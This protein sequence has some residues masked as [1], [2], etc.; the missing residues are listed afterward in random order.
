MHQI[1]ILKDVVI[2]F[3]LA[4]IVVFIF[5]KL[6]I[7]SVVGFLLTGILAGPH[8]LGLIN[9]QESTSILAEIGVVLLLFTIGIELSIKKLSKIKNIVFFGGFLQIVLS[10]FVT[11]LVLWLLNV[12]SN[13][14]VF[15]GFL[16]ALSSTAIILKI[17]QEQDQL[18]THH[19]KISI[20]ILI[21]QDLII[22]PMMLLIPMLSG[23][24]N[25]IG[26]EL[27]LMLGKSLLLIGITVVLARWLVP[28]ILHQVALLK[29]QELFLI[30]IFVIG[31]AVANL[32]AL[33][34][35]S[36]AL[37]AFLAGLSISESEYSHHAFGNLVPFRDIFTSFF[38]V[39]I[40]MLLDL[41]FFIDH[42]LIVL[43]V[44][45]ILIFLKSVV[46]GFVSFILGF[47]FKISFRAGLILAQ[48]GEFSFVLVQIGQSH[49]LID[50]F[51]YQLFLA[52]AILSMSF[53]PLLILF[54]DRIS[55]RLNQLPMPKLLKNGMRKLPT[56]SIQTLSRHSIL[57][58]DEKQVGSLM[59][60]FE[61]VDIPFI[62]IDLD[63]DRVR[64]LQ[65]KNINAIYGH[66][67][68][69]SVL[70]HAHIKEASNLLLSLNGMAI[71]ASIIEVAKNLN[72][73]VNIIVRTK[74]L[75]DLDYL[76]KVGADYV[77]LIEFE[78]SIE[79]FERALIHY[80]V[81]QTEINLTIAE[82]RS[83]GYEVFRERSTKKSSNYLGIPNLEISSIE[84]KAQSKI[85][86]K[87]IRELDIR[88]RTGVSIL[89]INRKGDLMTNPNPDEHLLEGDII[90]TMGE[91]SKSIC[92]NDYFN[93]T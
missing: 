81:P 67:Q 49:N 5:Q 58:G 84:I 7:P 46:I 15:I 14:A 92:I 32:S 62:I 6:K 73:N 33:L 60:A 93:E 30:I 29:S 16:V 66:A 43:F 85:I 22:V 71:N 83:R 37:G 52:T 72:P 9:D 21:F 91:F 57:V 34:G 35:L 1:E 28:Y 44:V 47:P 78:T 3:G 17:L 77:I 13:V 45:L 48:I 59:R 75:E 51:Y 69:E 50:G 90:Y 31:F 20:G 82:L 89:A 64:Q 65:K 80:L 19:G 54:S 40:G 10:I 88:Q 11:V 26:T 56:N 74:F 63:P 38:F 42:V 70:E 8:A 39:S 2:I 79:M 61:R 4:S 36:L 76:Y 53:T 25:N 68:Y 86:G 87:S 23:E 55:N 12:K 24:S 27:L 41:T 18:N